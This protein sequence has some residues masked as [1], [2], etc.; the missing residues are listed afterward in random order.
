MPGGLEGVWKAR[1]CQGARGLWTEKADS[2][3]R[4]RGGPAREA[5]LPG[6]SSKGLAE[7]VSNAVE[8]V[9]QDVP[10]PADP[11]RG[12]LH[13]AG[14]QTAIRTHP[15]WCPHPHAFRCSSP[16]QPTTTPQAFQSCCSFLHYVPA[17][18][19][20]GILRPLMSAAGCQGPGLMPQ[21]A[22]WWGGTPTG[23]RLC[24]QRRGRPRWC[25]R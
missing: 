18:L 23:R 12:I 2:D 1:W 5:L 11:V 3:C 21:N 22:A 8:L 6:V 25:A 15:A 13:S 24:G 19:W 20:S 9:K 4:E 10:P 17:G 14:A 16:A 7:T